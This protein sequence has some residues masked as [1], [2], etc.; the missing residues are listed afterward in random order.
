MR[1][2]P[3]RRA[4]GADL[5]AGT[6]VV[7][8]G[9]SSGIGLACAQAFARA[10]ARLVL[11]AREGPALHEAR[12]RLGRSCDAVVV[13]ADVSDEQDV[14]RVAAHAVARFGRIDVWVN[15]A[16]VIS[17]GRFEDTP[18]EDFRRVIE[19]NLFGQVHGSRAAVEQFRRQRAGVLINVSSLWGRVTSPHVSAYVTSKFAIRAFSD[20][21]REELADAPRIAV[22]TVLPPAIDTPIWQHA[23]NHS[24]RSVRPLP[25]VG[26]PE[27]VARRIVECAARPRREITIGASARALELLKTI[28]PGL[29]S[30]LVARLFN[31]LAFGARPAPPSAGT[32]FEPG[33]DAS[34]RGGWLPDG[35]RDWPRAARHWHRGAGSD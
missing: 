4:A 23:G 9:A 29:Y 3:A 27:D 7:I 25:P 34:A 1:V 6:V 13:P 15:C 24:G 5:A 21:L 20:C 16:G 18:P 8:T 10:G 12:E 11:S 28:A 32:L 19:T 22:V 33:R 2:R 14:R 26:E 30:P 17:F 35:L 31:R